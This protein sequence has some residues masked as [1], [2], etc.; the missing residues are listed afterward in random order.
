MR[1]CAGN[2]AELLPRA[3][4]VKYAATVGAALAGGR[5]EP[6]VAGSES[7]GASFVSARR[8]RL[9]DHVSTHLLV[10]PVSPVFARSAGM[11]VTAVVPIRFF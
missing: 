10:S 4:T 1:P 9:I 6:D 2:S 5:G 8:F 11:A 3:K 7:G